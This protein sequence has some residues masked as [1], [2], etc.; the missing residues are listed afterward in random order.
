MTFLSIKI[1]KIKYWLRLVLMINNIKDP[2]KYWLLLYVAIN[3]IAVLIVIDGRYLIGDVA[4]RKLSSIS[5]LWIA[6]LA[7]GISYFSI[8]WVVFGF[9][10]KIRF[11]T[12]IGSNNKLAAESYV[13]IFI[14]VTQLLYLMF[15]IITGANVSGQR[16]D[17]GGSLISAV[18][19]LLPI[20]ALFLIYYGVARDSKLFK[21]N[22]VIY[23][24]S[25]IMRGWAGVILIV[26]F[27]EFCRSYRNNKINFK[28]LFIAIIL[29]VLIYP[30]LHLLKYSF[31][32]HDLHSFF[33]DHQLLFKSIYGDVGYYTAIFE[34]IRHVV[35][36]IQI[37]SILT[38]VIENKSILKDYFDGGAVLPFWS[39][40]LHG[41]IIDRLFENER[42]LPIGVV[43]TSFGDFNWSFN[44]GEWVTNV[45]YPAW[46]FIV[47]EL[48]IFYIV[49]TLM[50]CFLS[51]ILMKS[52]SNKKS[53]MDMLWLSWLLYLLPPWFG[54]LIQFIYA[55]M[56][57]LIVN[58]FISNFL[59]KRR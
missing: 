42:G 41:I 44:V 23:L 16:G 12:L 35:E 18:W 31:R 52:I 59:V 32:V 15:N 24:V 45:G 10:S 17:V 21:H 20:D 56:I 30:E 36:R 33:F 57:Y 58:L 55:L 2:K 40:G 1:E 9:L 49:Y 5:N 6:F 7:V 51:M 37:V 29:V 19:A 8:L 48:S 25:N 39:E 53:A 46:F 26:I 54:T 34:G 27:M 13:G 14:L 4:G 43:F 22:L 47:P 50:V 28:Y 38:E 11:K 3:F